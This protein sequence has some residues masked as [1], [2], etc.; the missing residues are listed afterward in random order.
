MTA[1]MCELRKKKNT[2]SLFHLERLGQ[3]LTHTYIHQNLSKKAFWWNFKVCEA[4]WSSKWWSETI[5]HS[6]DVSI[7]QSLVLKSEKWSTKPRNPFASG[8]LAENPI[9]SK[10]FC[11][12]LWLLAGV[13]VPHLT[14]CK[15]QRFDLLID[16]HK[17]DASKRRDFYRCSVN[18]FWCAGLL[19]TNFPLYF[20]PCYFF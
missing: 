9:K 5:T 2:A 12:L 7:P 15:G 10:D 20:L 11:C 8:R 1:V 17:T 16:T 3:R 18:A 6:T 13:F 14:C 19:L 4:I